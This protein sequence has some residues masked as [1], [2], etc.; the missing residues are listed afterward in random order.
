M[1]HDSYN[2]PKTR[3]VILTRSD[4][5]AIIDGLKSVNPDLAI[6]LD[7]LAEDCVQFNLLCNLRKK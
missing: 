1:H 6:Q 4:F 5:R 3:E 2:N 7:L